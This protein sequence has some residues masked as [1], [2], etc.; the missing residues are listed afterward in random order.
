MTVGGATGAEFFV[1]DFTTRPVFALIGVANLSNC[2]LLT[3]IAVISVLVTDGA[4]THVAGEM[5]AVLLRL[6]DNGVNW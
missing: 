5:S 2:K 4:T 1:V 6:S 3:L